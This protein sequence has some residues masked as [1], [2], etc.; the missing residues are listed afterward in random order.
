MMSKAEP[1]FIKDAKILWK[2]ANELQLIFIS[3][4]KKSKINQ[5]GEI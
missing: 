3:I 1:S 2:E 5:K 4:I